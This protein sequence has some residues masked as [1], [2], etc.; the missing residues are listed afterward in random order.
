M[1]E[2][3]KPQNFEWQNEF[4]LSLKENC[5]DPFYLDIGDIHDLADVFETKEL[6]KKLATAEIHKDEQSTN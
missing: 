6:I 5:P 2:F 3:Q 4:R 1:N